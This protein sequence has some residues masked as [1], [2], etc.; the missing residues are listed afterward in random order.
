MVKLNTEVIQEKKASSVVFLS[1]VE[2]K[3]TRQS[4]LPS[5]LGGKGEGGIPEPIPNSA[6]KPLIADGSIRKSM[7]E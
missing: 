1:D 4:F 7:R 6:V 2:S 5:L 3:P